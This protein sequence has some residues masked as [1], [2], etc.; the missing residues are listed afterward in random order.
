MLRMLFELFSDVGMFSSRIT[1]IIR[2]SERNMIAS[3]P[4]ARR[5]F[6]VTSAL[7]GSM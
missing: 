4:R 3:N 7:R 6:P 1:S 5:F 2:F